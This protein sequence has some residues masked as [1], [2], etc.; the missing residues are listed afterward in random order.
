MMKTLAIIL[1][2][3]CIMTAPAFAV[4][5]LFD[6]WQ[7][8]DWDGI[9][10]TYLGSVEA[11]TGDLTGV[12]NYDYYSASGH[13]I[14]GPTPEAYLSKMYMYGG[15]DGLSF[16]FFHNI[17]EG[18]SN[19]WNHVRWEIDFINMNSNLGLVDDQTPENRGEIGMVKSGTHYD[20]GWSYKLNTDGGVIDQLQA[21]DPWW[22]IVIDPS[23]FGDIQMWQMASGDGS[24]IN[25]WENQFGIPGDIGPDDDYYGFVGDKRR[26]DAYTTFITPHDMIPEPT[27]IL[28]LGAGL[29]GAGMV[30]RKKKSK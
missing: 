25:L 10:D 27:T 28:L 20:A 15:S 8:T 4:P 21:T 1:T 22:E 16:G 6:V 30:A 23:M 13:P 18:G 2:F 9:R 3:C 12:A 19:Y 5:T 29:L 7:D 26:I 11:Y 17:D 24:Y 14:Y